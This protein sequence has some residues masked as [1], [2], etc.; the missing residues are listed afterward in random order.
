MILKTNCSNILSTSSLKLT[1][2]P[3]LLTAVSLLVFLP[4]NVLPNI[5]HQCWMEINCF[6]SFLIKS[7]SFHW[8]EA[9]IKWPALSGSCI[10]GTAILKT[11]LSGPN[12]SSKCPVAVG[13]RKESHPLLSAWAHCCHPSRYQPY[14]C[15]CLVSLLWDI[16]TSGAPKSPPVSNP[17]LTLQQA[18]NVLLLTCSLGPSIWKAAF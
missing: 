17:Q 6:S 15:I 3:S 9:L 12:T 10:Y 18:A 2:L 1:S 14:S 8:E 13:F 7:F 5:L 16:C 4:E 11:V